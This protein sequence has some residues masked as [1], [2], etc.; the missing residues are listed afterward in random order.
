MYMYCCLHINLLQNVNVLLLTYTFTARCKY[1]AVLHVNLL[2][3]VT[4]LLLTCKFTAFSSL[5]LLDF[6]QDLN[7]VMP[8]RQADTI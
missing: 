8:C 6:G 2:Q 3:D 7:K 1:T 5:A 4:V